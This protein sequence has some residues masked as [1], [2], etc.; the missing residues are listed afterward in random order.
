MEDESSTY[1]SLRA[2]ILQLPGVKEAPHRVGGVEFQVDG[3][4]FMHSHGP[5][6]LD[7]R[8][9][10]EDQAS[11]LKT[12]QALPHRAQVHSEA[13][14]VSLRIE[15]SQDFA[16]TKNVIQLA[17]EKAKKNPEDLKSR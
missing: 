17:Y 5:S 7:I 2:W 9:S 15:N 8:L 13:G 14:W 10:K 6:R 12:G 4:E 1:E 11:V 3:V 16:N